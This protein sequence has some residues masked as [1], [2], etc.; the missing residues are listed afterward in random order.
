MFQRRRRI[1]RIAI[2]NGQNNFHILEKWFDKYGTKFQFDNLTDQ[3]N[4]DMKIEHTKN[5]CAHAEKLAISLELD[6]EEV[7]LAKV[8]ALLHDV[9]RFTQYQNFRTYADHR[10][11]NHA[12]ESIRV[13]KKEKIVKFF[14]NEKQHIILQSIRYHNYPQ[15]PEIRDDKVE[16]FSK[17]LRDADKMDIFRVVTNYYEDQS[18]TENKTIGL[19]LPHSD[20]FSTEVLEQFLSEKVILSKKL[21]HLND[22]KILQLAWIFDLNFPFAVSYIVNNNYLQRIINTMPDS[23][24]VKKISDKIDSYL[25][26]LK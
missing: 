22:F 10:S 14:N 20:D 1:W 17:I 15:L 24:F 3:S 23:S 13:I 11:V 19:D 2:I 9:G 25:T 7:N 12:E 5:V 6:T 4:I 8:I 16:L 21:K 18:A 26:L